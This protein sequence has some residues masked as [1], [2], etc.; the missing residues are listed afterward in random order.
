MVHG[1]IHPVSIHTSE[2]I[3][4]GLNSIELVLPALAFWEDDATFLVYKRRRRSK[5]EIEKR[6]KVAFSHQEDV[7]VVTN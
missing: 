6:E 1:D 5:E 4:M 2:T 7:S 3:V